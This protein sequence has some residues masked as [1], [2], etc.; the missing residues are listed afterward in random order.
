V[1]Y[2][3]TRTLAVQVEARLA[4]DDFATLPLEIR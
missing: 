1:G 4:L 3:A 2:P